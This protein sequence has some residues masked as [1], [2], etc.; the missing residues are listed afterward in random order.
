ME[1]WYGYYILY[2]KGP[3]TVFG[4]GPKFGLAKLFAGQAG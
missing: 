3:E 2:E 4:T 1:A